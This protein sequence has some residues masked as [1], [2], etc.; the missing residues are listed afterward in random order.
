M[1]TGLAEKLNYTS[2]FEILCAQQKL[3]CLADRPS[4]D[5]FPTPVRPNLGK[6]GCNLA[7]LLTSH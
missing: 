7:K 5:R 4:L 2:L 3:N 1:K 6:S